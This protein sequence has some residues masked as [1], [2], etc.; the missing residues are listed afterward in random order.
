MCASIIKKF[1]WSQP[2]PQPENPGPELARTKVTSTMSSQQ[3][4]LLPL[5]DDGSPDLPGQYIYLPPP[6]TPAYIVRFIIE[7]SS[8]ICREGTLWINVPV[9]GQPFD[10][11]KFNGFR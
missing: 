4:Y 2:Q 1:R 9:D 11:A 5:K 8:S 6:T 10:R 7:G 3:V